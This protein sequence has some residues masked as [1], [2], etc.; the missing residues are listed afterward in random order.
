MEI[1]NKNNVN[2]WRVCANTEKFQ[3]QTANH[4]SAHIFENKLFDYAC[5]SFI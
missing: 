1:V 5:V 2:K 3:N 4:V